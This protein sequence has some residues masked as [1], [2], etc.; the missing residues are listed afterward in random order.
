MENVI[1]KENPQNDQ[2]DEQDNLK[3][4]DV[5]QETDAAALQKKVQDLSDTN[6]KLFARAKQA[7]GFEF[8]DE[9]KRWE[10]KEKPP[11]KAPDV[12]V[13]PKA[14]TGDSDIESLVL[15]VKGITA[16]D[17]IQLFEK[18]K[19][20][21]QRD[22]R[23][24]LNNGVFQSELKFLRDK[25]AQEDATPSAHRTSQAGK[26]RVDLL[27][28]EYERTKKL[29]DDFDLRAKVIDVVAAKHSQN[30]PPWRR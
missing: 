22:A 11:A 7:E 15:E 28:A 3:T 17:E 10:K 27:V 4:V 29:P 25:K 2:P 1:G 8:N 18:W 24:I 19:K 6:R 16:D 5:S 20:D 30:T 26:D 21:T 12:E 9:S 23:S 13:A 14:K